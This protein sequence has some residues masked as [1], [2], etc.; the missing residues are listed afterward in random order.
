V[1]GACGRGRAKQDDNEDAPGH[2]RPL[3]HEF[4]WQLRLFR[5]KETTIATL[6]TA[7][8]RKADDDEGDEDDED[9]EDER[10]G[11]AGQRVGERRHR[12]RAR[13]VRRSFASLLEAHETLELVVGV[14]GS[15]SSSIAA[16]TSTA[17]ITITTIHVIVVVFRVSRCQR[18]RGEV[19]EGEG[20]SQRVD[21]LPSSLLRLVACTGSEITQAKRDI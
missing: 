18:R 16:A 8:R 19:D 12:S 7:H 14:L 21:T 15:S 3:L 5:R 9:D 6:R 13:F 20:R 4:N 10:K 1:S 17:T 11:R 2:E